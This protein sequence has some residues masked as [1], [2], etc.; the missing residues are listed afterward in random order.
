MNDT[1]TYSGLFLANADS[2]VAGPS[3]CVERS[4]ML[5]FGGI[6]TAADITLNGHILGRVANAHRAH[7]FDVGALLEAHV[8]NSLQVTIHSA[9]RYAR[10][11]ADVYPY[12]VPYSHQ[13]GSVGQYN[14]IRKAASDFGW[15]WAGAFA[16]AGI[17]KSVE[18]IIYDQ[19]LLMDVAVRQEHHENGSITLCA[20]AYLSPAVAM[21]SGLLEL[22]LFGNRKDLTDPVGEPQKT[23]T[24]RTKI[25]FSQA[26]AGHL[27]ND[28]ASFWAFYAHTTAS[29]TNWAPR[30]ASIDAGINA[31]LFVRRTICLRLDPPVELDLWW[32]WDAALG[33]NGSRRPALYDITLSYGTSSTGG[34]ETTDTPG[35]GFVVQKMHRKIGLRTV[36]LKR[37][38][39]ASGSGE[40][41]EFWVNNERI[42]A[43]GA[44]VIPID[45]YETRE[46]EERLHAMVAAARSGNFNMLRV[47][48]G[49]RYFPG[50]FLYGLKN[51][52][53]PLC[54]LNAL[55]TS[56]LFTFD[57]LYRRVLR[58]SG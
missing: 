5:R 16:P 7:A 21:E 46:E 30:N 44:N 24:S 8:N 29:P 32:P 34:S 49:G 38:P 20:E 19:A 27:I 9:P 45:I 15:D 43:R 57:S 54:D 55:L 56:S 39:T 17:S 11:Q 35:P 13:L 37:N 36:E 41:F 10:Q 22:T 33:H 31:P 47:W 50:E 14:F 12:I 6:D 28:G 4:C 53:R 18:L 25:R 42:F 58:S 48:G 1:L 2:G 23:W 52:R 3:A 51:S 26:E 40:T